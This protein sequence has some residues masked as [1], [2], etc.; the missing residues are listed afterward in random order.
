L[1]SL[2]ERRCFGGYDDR[3]IPRG[4]N[5]VERDFEGLT[6]TY[7]IRLDTI[8]FTSQDLNA[9]CEP[10]NSTNL[11][12]LSAF[13]GALAPS[14]ERYGDYDCNDVVNVFDLAFFAAGLG[15]GC[16]AAPCP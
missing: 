14:Y 4:A 5:A 15:V 3:A 11:F 7:L 12:D 6:G 2:W 1:G 13:A 10:S 16:A 9:S 8:E